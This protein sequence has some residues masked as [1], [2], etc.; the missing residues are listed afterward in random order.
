MNYKKIVKRKE[1]EVYI[2]IYI[3]W[4]NSNEAKYNNTL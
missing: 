1:N 2:Y 4:I 3:Y